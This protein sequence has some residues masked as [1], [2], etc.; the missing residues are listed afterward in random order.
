MNSNLV[1]TSSHFQHLGT[2]KAACDLIKKLGA[3]VVECLV[4]IE[5]TDLK[6]KEKLS[7][8]FFTLMAFEGE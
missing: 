8:P 2:M 3:E 6:G 7:D 4:L 5:L 1:L